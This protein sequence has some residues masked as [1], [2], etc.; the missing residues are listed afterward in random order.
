MLDRG[1]GGY[2]SSTLGDK[3]LESIMDNGDKA[4]DIYIDGG[5]IYFPVEDIAHIAIAG[6]VDQQVQT[7]QFLDQRF[8]VGDVLRSRHI[9]TFRDDVIGKFQ[10]Q[11]IEEVMS[12]TRD[13]YQVPF[14][15]INTRQFSSYPGCIRA[16]RRM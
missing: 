15:G 2:L 6:I 13:P 8:Q 9:K 11:G 10:L 3:I 4:I 5:L 14:A 1:G 7:V 12:A 16:M